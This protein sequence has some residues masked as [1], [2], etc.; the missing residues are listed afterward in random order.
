MGYLILVAI[1]M[2]VLVVVLMMMS[3]DSDVRPY[4]SLVTLVG[5]VFMLVMTLLNSF[6]EVDAGNVGLIRSFGAIVGQRSEG[7]Q[8][9]LPWQSLEEASVRVEGHRFVRA[10][11]P[12]EQSTML[13][14]FSKETQEVNVE[15]TLN[16]HVSPTHI[17]QLY[18]T[19]GPRYFDILVAP[20][21]LQAFKDE[22]VKYTSVEVAPHREDIRRVVRE[23]LIRELK[24]NSID[25][26][27]LLI[28]NIAFTKK[29]QDAIEEKQS[30]SQL[31]LAEREKVSAEK[32]K[33]DQA[34]EVARGKAGAVLVEAQKQAEANLVLAE[35]E[36]KANDLVSKSITP[37]LTQYTY[38]QK[39]APNV[40]VMMIP[41]GQQMI[42]GP[43]V[44]SK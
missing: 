6:W 17:Q 13:S 40:S 5:M 10:K 24:N 8:W 29:F 36:A 9:Y 33:A 43:S 20:R 37:Q 14:C 4:R 42:I 21:V 25:V 7:L 28:D 22:V 2:C 18:R 16:V 19:V 3:T 35:A 1:F 30:Q 39:L 15:A 34:L 31:A 44:L 32:A 27:D 41:A 23:R 12:E 26:Q 11:T 38:A